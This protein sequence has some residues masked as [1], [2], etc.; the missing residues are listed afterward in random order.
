MR[1]VKVINKKHLHN[2]D[3]LR[4]FLYEID[5]LKDLDHPNVLKVFEYFLDDDRLYIVT[6]FVEGKEL[7][8]EVNRKK[9]T[10]EVCFEEEEAALLIKQ[11][12]TVLNYCHQRNIVHRDIK[13]ENIMIESMPTVKDPETPW[14]IKLI[15]FGTAMKFKKGQ[16]LK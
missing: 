12:L 5:I 13:L 14:Q 9:G 2:Q 1:A 15:D 3:S 8:Q 6:E 11:L 10:K 7:L 16:M 4:R